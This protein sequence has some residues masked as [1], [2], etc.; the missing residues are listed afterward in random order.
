MGRINNSEMFFEIEEVSP[1]EL[2]DKKRKKKKF[3][4]YPQE[5]KP[6]TFNGIPTY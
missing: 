6:F 4:W 2:D 5:K 1:K 3:E